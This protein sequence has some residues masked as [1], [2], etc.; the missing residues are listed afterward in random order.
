M[1]LNQEALEAARDTYVAVLDEYEWEASP[2]LLNAFEKG[3]QAGLD[4]PASGLV[5][6]SEI[7]GALR[8]A[9]VRGQLA[10]AE[11]RDEARRQIAALRKVCVRA[12]QDVRSG[13]VL[14]ATESIKAALAAAPNPEA[15]EGTG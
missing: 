3:L 15:D 5:E 2:T 14:K 9:E 6:R 12:L 4:H 1:K 11:E 8:R 13:Y 7:A 10:T